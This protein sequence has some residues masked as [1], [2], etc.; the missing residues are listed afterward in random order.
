MATAKEDCFKD[1]LKKYKDTFDDTK[2]DVEVHRPWRQLAD[3]SWVDDRGLWGAL[4]SFWRNLRGQGGSTQQVR[5]P[6]LTV[7]D[8]GRR[9]VIDLKFDRPSGGRDDWRTKPG[10][11]NGQDQKQ[12]YNDINRQLND[13]NSQHGDDPKMD[14][15][16][17]KCNQ[18]GGTA[19]EPV[20]VTAD[21]YSGQ[22]FVAP[23]ALAPNTVM[24]PVRL[25]ALPGLQGLNGLL[26]RPLAP[27]RVP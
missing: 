6:D 15:D 8:G 17:C 19:V 3:G 27:A 25:P 4:N 14:A 26:G 12:D 5:I 24:P 22:Y 2:L 1:A 7:N 20:T 13:G 23:G 10:P 11:I 16:T 9:S 18:P 21:A